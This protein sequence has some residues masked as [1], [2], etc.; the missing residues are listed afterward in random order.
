MMREV[1]TGEQPATRVLVV[2]DS[3]DTVESTARLLR[4]HGHEIQTAC[5]A[6]EAIAVALSWRPEVV[7]LDLGLPDMDGYQVALRLRQEASFQGTVII[8][9]TGYG[10]PEDRRQSREAGIDLHLLKPVN[11][12]VLLALLAQCGAGSV[13]RDPRRHSLNRSADLPGVE[14]RGQGHHG[15]S[16]GGAGPPA[17]GAPPSLLAEQAWRGGEAVDRQV[18]SGLS[19]DRW[20]R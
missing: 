16:P 14:E 5:D 3:V 18:P 7:L 15:S 10:R 13:E 8:A 11:P 1:A 17:P 6:S 4:L 20:Y 2:D 19:G 9:V 12:D